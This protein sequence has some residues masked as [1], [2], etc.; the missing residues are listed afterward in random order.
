MSRIHC[1]RA[2]YKL[3][4]DF[5]CNAIPDWLSLEENWQGYKISTVPWVADAA[6]VLGILAIQDTP[7]EWIAHLES[8]GLKEITPIACEDFFEEKFYC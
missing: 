2:N 4:I 7:E 6:R 1:F 5:N 3:S 8:L